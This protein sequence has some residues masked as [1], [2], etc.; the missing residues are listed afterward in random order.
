MLEKYVDAEG[1]AAE[2]INGVVYTLR[3]DIAVEQNDLQSAADLFAKALASS[4]DVQTWETNSTKLALVYAAM[5]DV[6]KAQETY[7]ALV[8][9]FP[10]LKQKYA[11]YI[12]E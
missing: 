11:K 10:E 5:G 4:A 2:V 12:A 6:A 7:K 3:G 9:R 1:V 8:A